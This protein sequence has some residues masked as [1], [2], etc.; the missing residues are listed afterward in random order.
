MFG[1]VN[2]EKKKYGLVNTQ[3]TWLDKVSILSLQTIFGQFV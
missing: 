3:N 2:Q 1:I